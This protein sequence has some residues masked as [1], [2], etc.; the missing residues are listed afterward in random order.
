MKALL[1]CTKSKPYIY[2]K[3]WRGSESGE[4]LNGK[5]VAE[6]DFEVEELDCIHYTSGDVNY[7]TIT[8]NTYNLLKNSCLT[9][10]ELDE[11]L[12]EKDGYAIHIKNLKIFDEPREL[13]Y[14]RCK[15]SL[16]YIK[17]APQNMM[18][19]YEL[20]DNCELHYLG[21][22]IVERILISIRPEWLCKI[23]NGEKTIE[24]RKKVLKEMIK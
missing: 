2:P 23:L 22:N 9:Y 4:K 8:L 1:Y 19:I 21:S 15:K 12:K 24:V 5:I 3:F 14:Y 18:Y 17:Q 11:Y 10:E 7:C 6:C 20:I 13:S 16:E